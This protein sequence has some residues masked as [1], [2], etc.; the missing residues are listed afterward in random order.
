MLVGC[1]LL[2]MGGVGVL[3]VGVSCLGFVLAVIGLC[4]SC[5]DINVGVWM[6]KCWLFLLTCAR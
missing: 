4:N 1:G 2:V 5:Y 6:L 3:V